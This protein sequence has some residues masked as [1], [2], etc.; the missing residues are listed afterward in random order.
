MY[1][2]V[3]QP[4]RLR[5]FRLFDIGTGAPYFDDHTNRTIL[6]RVA[7]KCYLPAN[8]L[9]K[10]AIERSGG[11]FKIA[12]SLSGVLLDQLEADA[13]DVLASFQELVATG[14]VELLGETYY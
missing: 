3:H 5:H 12:L 6:R 9:F 13:P 7:D 1:C 14:G 10:E 11:Q 8:R 2:Q 4:F